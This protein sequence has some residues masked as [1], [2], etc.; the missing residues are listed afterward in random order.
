[1]SA[2][3]LSLAAVLVAGTAAAQE[4]PLASDRVRAREVVDS[5]LVKG[6]RA[7]L[8]GRGAEAA[9]RF[10]DAHS[11]ARAIAEQSGDSLCLRRLDNAE[12]IP[13]E[14]LPVHTD[15]WEQYFQAREL[16]EASAWTE[17]E[18]R[19]ARIAPL[20]RRIGD[21][22]LEE[23]TQ[24]LHGDALSR[25]GRFR[26][27]LPEYELALAIA[28]TQRDAILENRVRRNIIQCRLTLNE[29]GNH[30]EDL[31]GIYT[32]SESAGDWDNAVATLR[33]LGVYFGMRGEADSARVVFERGLALGREHGVARHQAAFLLNLSTLDQQQ[34]QLGQARARLEEALRSARAEGTRDTR[35]ELIAL[36][37]L[38]SLR[39]TLAEYS[40]SLALL[41]E[42]LPLAEASGTQDALAD[43]R[44]S[45][46]EVYRLL[47]RPDEALREYQAMLPIVRRLDLRSLEIAALRASGHA[48][49]SRGELEAARQCL[50][51]AWECVEGTQNAQRRAVALGDLG[52]IHGLLGEDAAAERFLLRAHALADSNGNQPLLAGLE[53]DMAELAEKRGGRDAALALFDRSAERA[54]ATRWTTLLAEVYLAKAR[55]LR[56]AGRLEE[57]DSLLVGSLEIVESLRAGQAGE[58]TR[59]GFQSESREVYTERASLLREL[60]ARRT[61]GGP[62]D[63]SGA[64]LVEA[65]RVAEM[66]QARALLD[67]LGGDPPPPDEAVPVA[68]RER[69]ETLRHRLASLQTQLSR[70]ASRDHWDAATIDSLGKLH[71]NASRDFQATQEE[72]AVRYPNSLSRLGTRS[73]LDLEE[74]RDRVLAEDEM[75]IEYLV[76]KDETLV[77]LLDRKRFAVA[78][79][80]AGA[81]SLARR[82]EALRRL[83]LADAAA[84]VLR[85]A[86]AGLYDLL[87]GASSLAVPDGVRLLIVPDG[88]LHYLPF[89]A[90][91]DGTGFL[92]ERHAISCAP[93]A[94][95]LDVQLEQRRRDRRRATRAVLAV[96]DPASY[97]GKE[98]LSERRGAMGTGAAW[99][100]GELP[101]AAEEARRVARRFGE[102]R[103]LVGSEATEEAVKE[104]LPEAACVHFAT[105]AI[106]NETDPALSGMVLAQDDDPAEDGFLQAHEVLRTRLAADLVSLSACNTGLGTLVRGEGVL[107]LTRAFL[108]A[109]AQAVLISLWEVPDR[110]T[111]DLMDDFYRGY[112]EQGLPADA[113]LRTAQRDAI[114][115][116]ASVREWAPFVLVGRGDVAARTATRE[117]IWMAT[118]V[119]AAGFGLGLMG[120]LAL[121]RR[122]AAA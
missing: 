88:P 2:L 35:Y 108:C 90:L 37:S 82:V 34:G 100:F 63:S 89:A 105:H 98:L 109:G 53:K 33:T 25:L 32:I 17:A 96:G 16:Y 101:F 93:S 48:Q 67:F 43:V 118:L 1:M 110:S 11:L 95:L 50:Q 84:P 121:R 66:A 7:R 68:L 112:L 81:D 85:E 13:P 74:I 18:S 31:R 15:A 107:G 70:V 9:A 106:L 30:Q 3:R 29:P 117:R 24:S 86:A 103:V 45:I 8:E 20:A 42:A 14:Q 21:P 97:R 114:A 116:G 58:G 36:L 49:A 102:R 10:D 39:R 6:L 47:G 44:Y 75:L 60:G 92:V 83:I 22:Y 72:I 113:A 38:A 94:S 5:L 91:H 23:R 65:F 19:A 78:H 51:Q 59:M 52:W 122:R 115:S 27:A 64:P 77:F 56:R 26:E 87:L 57:A 73:P 40:A 80:A 76:G 55:C 41:R 69:E 54:R 119:L 111:A 79:I 28:R 4:L 46:G 61:A 104:A 71:E 62:A 12:M 120:R 99:Q